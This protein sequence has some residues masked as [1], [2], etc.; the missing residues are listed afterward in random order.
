[1]T[2][3][4]SD[5]QACLTRITEIGKTRREAKGLLCTGNSALNHML[6]G[7]LERGRVTQ[8]YGPSGS[9]K[10]G[11]VG[12]ILGHVADLAL[13]TCVFIDADHTAESAAAFYGPLADLQEN[14][15]IHE[16]V[17]AA[18]AASVAEALTGCADLVVVDSL[19][20]FHRDDD[21]GEAPGRLVRR[22]A[23]KAERSGAVV[24]VTNQVRVDIRRG[25][26]KKAYG[27]GL[28]KYHSSKV[29]RLESSPLRSKGVRVGLT[30]AAVLEKSHHG[31]L[32]GSQASWDL[33]YLK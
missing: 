22:L 6:G 28:V 9:G 25:G 13:G 1:M 18:E 4:P 27:D 24:I 17:T 14:A 20:A 30:I 11:T 5:L 33:E 10:S 29:I 32:N 31:P 15:L 19:G 3:H 2:S 7:G 23:E 8:L 26:Q 12:Q 21:D 16:P